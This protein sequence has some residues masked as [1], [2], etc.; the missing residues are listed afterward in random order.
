MRLATNAA[1]CLPWGLEPR[2][3][4]GAKLSWGSWMASRGPCLPLGALC[5]PRLVQ[6]VLYRLR[7]SQLSPALRTQLGCRN[8]LSASRIRPQ[9][10]LLSVTSRPGCLQ[11]C[12]QDALRRS[13]AAAAAA[14]SVSVHETRQQRAVAEQ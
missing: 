12:S 6:R 4:C 13:C 9:L 2:A 7:R 8:C 10:Q 14:C 11:R 3:S 5:V 1:C